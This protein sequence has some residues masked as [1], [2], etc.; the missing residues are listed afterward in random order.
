LL[1]QTRRRRVG[2][3]FMVGG[4]AVAYLAS[5]SL[6]G[7]ALLAPLEDEYPPAEA[8]AP[9][10]V[11]EVVVLGSGYDPRDH[12]PAAAALGADGLVRIV[13]G[14]RLLRSRPG[15]RLVVSGGASPGFAPAAE[16]Y[17]RLAVEL[18]IQRSEMLV[19]GSARDTEEE[20]RDV[21]AALGHAP[22][23]LVTSAYHM[24]RAMRL[25]RRAGA[26]PIPA[27]TGQLS[28]VR[29]GLE[30]I[31]IRPG[32]QGLRMT[33]AALHEYLGLVLLAFTGPIPSVRDSKAP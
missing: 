13:E 26:S 24:P 14:I 18:G 1:F 6:V 3:W 12:V 19:L 5:T 30:R 15:A 11:R 23:I 22:F 33:E 8:V 16:G 29:P 4:A 21:V 20:A 10:E 27:P 32:S 17:A 31:G 7:N 28:H 2:A 25:M 9:T